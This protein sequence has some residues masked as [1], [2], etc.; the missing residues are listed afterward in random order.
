MWCRVSSRSAVAVV[1]L[2]LAVAAFAPSASALPAYEFATPIFGLA[3]RGDVL[4]VADAGA[5]A[6]RLGAVEGRLAR[7]P[8][9]ATD[10]APLLHGRMWALTSAHHDRKVYRVGD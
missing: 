9:G 6:V 7:P 3:A 5:G 10:V 2:A 1:A 4:L 8:P